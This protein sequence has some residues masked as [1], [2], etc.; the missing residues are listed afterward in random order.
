MLS[1][2]RERRR[3][4]DVGTAETLSENMDVELCPL[5]EVL[6]EGH[7]K[8]LDTHSYSFNPPTIPQRHQST[9][10]HSAL[11]ASGNQHQLR[12]GPSLTP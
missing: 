7:L 12:T 4:E 8:D 10:H 6:S 1:H 2:R 5:S 9:F 3:D 11:R